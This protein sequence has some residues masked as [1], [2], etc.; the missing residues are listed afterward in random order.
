MVYE[1][2]PMTAKI[3]RQAELPYKPYGAVFNSAG[4]HLY[5]AAGDPQGRILEVEPATLRV[6]REFSSGGH[7]PVAPVLSADERSLFVCNRFSNEVVQISRT[8]SCHGCEEVCVAPITCE[9]KYL[10]YLL[11]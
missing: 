1:I 9:K 11:R 2:D 8:G 7:T 6:V 5:V 3:S 10:S 4:D